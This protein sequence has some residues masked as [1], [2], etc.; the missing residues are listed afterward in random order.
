MDMIRPDHATDVVHC[1]D[2]RLLDII[3]I[4]H[5]ELK[6]GIDDH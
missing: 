2:Y 4:D 1:N 6:Y 5:S 3:G